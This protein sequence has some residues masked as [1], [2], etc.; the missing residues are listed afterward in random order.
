MAQ[1]RRLV[2]HRFLVGASN[3][4][5]NTESGSTSQVQG[6]GEVVNVGQPANGLHIIWRN[7]TESSSGTQSE[8]GSGNF[9]GCHETRAAVDAQHQA[10]FHVVQAR[11]SE[12]AALLRTRAHMIGAVVAVD[13]SNSS[14]GSFHQD[15]TS[16]EDI[17]QPQEQADAGNAVV[18]QP[19]DDES[20]R[21][22]LRNVLRGLGIAEHKSFTTALMASNLPHVDELSVFW[23]TGVTGHETGTCRPCGFAYNTT[24]CSHG[25]NCEFCHLPH[26]PGQ[27]RPCKQKRAYFHRFTEKLESVYTMQP[28]TF[29]TILRTCVLGRPTV[30]AL[31]DQWFSLQHSRRATMQSRGSMIMSL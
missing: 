4:D 11:G 16:S 29:M 17:P 8:S 21:V 6:S 18:Q 23:S 20:S 31:V 3:S 19:V 5:S 7:G 25:G 10:N 2:A 22:L 27:P 26:P 12:Q 24:G 28:A 15:R 30:L 1:D 9:G 13:E 14:A